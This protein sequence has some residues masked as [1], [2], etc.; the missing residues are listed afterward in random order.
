MSLHVEIC[1]NGPYLALLHGWGMHGGI[2]DGVR[3]DLARHFRVHVVDLPGYGASQAC[4]PY[5]L[6]GLAQAVAGALPQGISLIGWSLGGLVAQRMALDWPRQVERL[7][8]V[9]SSPCFVRRADWA[10]GIDAEV[11]RAF[12]R[13]LEQDYAGTLLRFLSLQARSGENLRTVMKYLRV[14]LFARG[15]PETGVLQ[16]GL[17]ILLDSDLRDEAT[18]LSPPVCLVHGERDMLVPPD[19]ARWLAERAPDARLRMI[20]GSAH[21]PFLSHPTAFVG[22]VREFFS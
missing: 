16:A 13:D 5:D 20:G 14:A 17:K 15:V 11:L 22:T 3:D 12:A 9:G 7:M 2:W 8:L 6:G 1:G 10:H 19:A 4:N 21:A 18:A